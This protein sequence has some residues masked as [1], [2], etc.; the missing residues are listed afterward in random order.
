MIRPSQQQWWPREEQGRH[1]RHRLVWELWLVM[2]LLGVGGRVLAQPMLQTVD[3]S[4][5][6]GNEVQLR[7]EFSE[8]VDDP[9]T[10]TVNDPARIVLD[11]PGVRSALAE[12]QREIDSGVAESVTVL[13]GGDRTRASINL[14]RLVP[15]NFRR[16]GNTLLVTLEAA[17]ATSA[18]PAARAPASTFAGV[19]AR[20]PVAP[21]LVQTTSILSDI[22]FRRGPQGEAIITIGL[23]E[24]SATVQVREEGDR[25][26]A[27]FRG[28]R[29][30]AG[31]ERRLDV[32]DFATPVTLIDAI[33]RGDGA[34]ITVLP[35][36]LYE[37]LAYQTDDAYTIEVKPVI[38]E[39]EPDPE[40]REYTGELLSL[41]FQDIEVRAVLQIIADFTGLNVVVSDT[42]QGNLTL[43]LQNVPWDQALDIILRTK[44]LDQRQNGNVI[45]I[46]PTEELLARERLRLEGQQDVA[47]LAPLR[48]EI[49]QV[50]YAEAASLAE[51]LR[52]SQG[53]GGEEGID[54]GAILSSRG[55][56]TVDTRTNSLLV[57]DI[58]EK[59]SEVRALIT[60][61]DVPVRQVLIDSRVVIARDDYSRELGVRFGG[62]VVNR[63][64]D[65]GLISTSGNL[66][67][68]TA[69]TQSAIEN[70][71][72]TG[73]PFPV[74][75]PAL[76]DRLGI[77][78]GIGAPTTSL[79]FAILGADYL[80]DLELSAL[81][82]EGRGEVL[83]NPRVITT[84]GREASILQ[85]REIPFQ[86]RGDDGA[87]TVAFREALLQLT[88]LP[89]IT[90]DNRVIMD[91]NI[92]K[93]ELGEQVQTGT[94]TEPSIDRREVNTQVL[95][96]DG[97]TVVLGG[98][99]ESFKASDIDK[100][101][102]LGDLPVLGNLFKRT[103]VQ[104]DR[105]ELLIFVTPQIV[106]DNV[107]V[108]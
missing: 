67:G 22:D 47:R 99:F 8:P 86:E 27:D 35:T 40:E 95:V 75:V 38:E 62:S 18:T 98:V 66:G 3:V 23:S 93:D 14:A 37:Y 12:T 77:N 85:G 41:N 20:T 105:L 2:L 9:S 72:T 58:P 31:Q 32:T 6:P 44:G 21:D 71:Q 50:N 49:I 24:P 42:V 10:F 33:N 84:D 106:D 53:V 17:G 43:R 70:L 13:E 107:A 68:T 82:A 59:L 45:Y 61:L 29:L 63:T 87:I 28:V 108:R 57:S 89:R 46:A 78:L 91:L 64:S 97:E 26:V 52:Q 102:I 100:T 79:A 30:P 80:L 101:P 51:I 36:G 69:I 16:Q 83:S 7:F 4:S 54:S 88:V 1:R 55:S 104:D 65:R 56:V 73:Q 11:F 5:L 34:R 94:G 103:S 96:N 15:Y 60:R 19:P 76:S 39:E 74:A 90:P 81:Q 92:L 48:S 25:I